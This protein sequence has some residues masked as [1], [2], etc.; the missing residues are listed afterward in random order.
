MRK[1]W[2][3]VFVL[4]CTFVVFLVVFDITAVVVK[5]ATYIDDWAFTVEIL[6]WTIAAVTFIFLAKLLIDKDL[7]K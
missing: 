5:I 2:S 1:V 4:L 3:V 6:W 7:R